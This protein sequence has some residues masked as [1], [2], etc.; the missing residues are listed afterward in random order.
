MVEKGKQTATPLL[1]PQAFSE[2]IDA[3]HDDAL[4]LLDQRTEEYLEI[5]TR[6]WLPQ[7]YEKN[8]SSRAAV[9]TRRALDYLA[10][11]LEKRHDDTWLADFLER[12]PSPIEG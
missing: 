8:G 1:S 9:G 11:A 10:Q 7:L 3:N 5:A 12:P 4:A 2:A 6:L